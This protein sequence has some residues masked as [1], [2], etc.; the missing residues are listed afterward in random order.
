MSKGTKTA[1]RRLP[2][3]QASD[4]ID[5][6]FDL[7]LKLP[8]RGEDGE[9]RAVIFQFERVGRLSAALFGLIGDRNLLEVV[10]EGKWPYNRA[11]VRKVSFDVDRQVVRVGC[12]L[13]L[14]WEKRTIYS[15]MAQAKE[16]LLANGWH[17][18]S[19]RKDELTRVVKPVW[20]QPQTEDFNDKP[21]GDESQIPF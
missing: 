6:V 14:A 12:Q 15:T 19:H 11:Q 2:A 3:P 7:Y 21:L 10:F 5:V 4:G 8:V 17:Y 13:L 16:A 18:A 9:L 20:Q 1:K